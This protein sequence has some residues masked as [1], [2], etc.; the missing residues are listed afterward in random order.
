MSQK[1]PG[2]KKKL[3][4]RG[5]YKWAF[6]LW[7]MFVGGEVGKRKYLPGSRF[8]ESYRWFKHTSVRSNL[9]SCKIPLIVALSCRLCCF[10]SISH[11]SWSHLQPFEAIAMIYNNCNFP[12]QSKLFV[13]KKFF[14][15]HSFILH[16]L[17]NRTRPISAPYDGRCW[18][19]SNLRT[20]TCESPDLPSCYGHRGAPSWYINLL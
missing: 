20:P 16:H 11:C 12:M 18:W 9:V 19:N 14:F 5:A 3:S 6:L 13:L 7:Y 17:E 10:E 1:N 4:A 2:W 15:D 8:M